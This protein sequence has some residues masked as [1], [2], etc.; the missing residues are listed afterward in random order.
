MALQLSIACST[1]KLLV[2]KV[3]LI[4]EKLK[5]LRSTNIG[6]RFKDNREKNKI[7]I[8]VKMNFFGSTN[9]KN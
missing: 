1:V 7:Y 9:N 5:N 3:T 4:L 8:K 2:F 6:A